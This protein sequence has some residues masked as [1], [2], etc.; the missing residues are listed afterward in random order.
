MEGVMRMANGGPRILGRVIVLLLLI[1]IL[2]AGGLLWFDYLNVVDA[3]TLLAPAFR[4]IGLVP[5]TQG[6]TALDEFI[7]LDAERLAV[8]LEAQELH[9]REL[10]QLEQDLIRRQ[11]DMEQQAQE[12]EQRQKALD[13]Q[14]LSLNAQAQDAENRM[15]NV[16]QNARYLAGMPPERA[17]GIIGRMDDQ[18]AIDVFRM[19]EEIARREG[20]TSIVAYWLSLLPPERAA[21]L[22]RKMA[23]RPRALN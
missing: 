16:E 9:A 13:E 17:V 22:Q 23:G 2:A 21:E 12:L 14:A 4:L 10:E 11:N 19:T 20:T 3:K 5:R 7:S 6:D 15:N 1:A 8:R 18:D